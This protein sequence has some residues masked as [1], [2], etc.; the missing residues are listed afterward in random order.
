MNILIEHA[1]EVT[2]ESLIPGTIFY[3]GKEYYM[4]VADASECGESNYVCLT[5]GVS[6]Y[7]DGCTNVLVVENCTLT[8]KV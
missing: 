7:V 3:K 5:T 2:L 8:I 6:G 1:K 4:K